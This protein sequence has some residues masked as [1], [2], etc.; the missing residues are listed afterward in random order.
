MDIQTSHEKELIIEVINKVA[1]Y[2]D[3]RQWDKF[4]TEVFEPEVT[5]DYRSL[6]GGNVQTSK[7][8]DVIAGWKSVLPGFKSTQHLLGNHLVKIVGDNATAIAYV[9]AHHYLPNDTG[10]DT[11][12]VGGY[13]DYEFVRHGKYDWRIKLMRL[14]MQYCEGNMNLL[15]L[16]QKRVTDSAGK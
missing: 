8:E 11:W 16:A 12:V 14:N 13:Y 3:L 6:F 2:A 15:A 7:V 5:L 1:I 10:S 4:A 9:R